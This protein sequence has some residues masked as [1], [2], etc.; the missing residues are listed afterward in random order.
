MWGAT[1][2]TVASRLAKDWAEYQDCKGVKVTFPDPQDTSVFTIHITPVD[3][4][5]KG[6]ERREKEKECCRC[7]LTRETIA[8]FEFEASVP[9]GYPHEPPVIVLKTV[10]IYHPNINFEGKI[11]LNVLRDGWQPV[12][13]ITH[14]IYGLLLLFEQPNPHDP[15][16]NGIDGEW[17]AANLLRKD[18]RKFEEMVNSTLEG[19]FVRR[20]NKQ[21]PALKKGTSN[22]GGRKSYN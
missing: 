12:M 4:Y 17:E 5:W 7:V 10:P 15:L 8:T 19:G 21:F 9:L 13:T 11:C 14:V 6:G 3:G 20:L 22:G 2:L 16:P 1:I 18:P